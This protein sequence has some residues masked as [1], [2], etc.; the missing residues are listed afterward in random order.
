VV[1]KNDQGEVIE[2]ICSYDPESKGGDTPDGRRVKGTLQWVS[3]AHAVEAEV[4]LFDR[5]FG[6]ENPAK[7]PE[8]EDFTAN[9]NADSLTIL[10]GCKLEPSLS[11]AKPGQRFQY[12]RHGYFCVD[13]D[14]SGEKLVFN[15]TVPL[16]DSW[17]KQ[18]AGNKKKQ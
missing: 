5:L 7:A 13:P 14:S 8:G 12:M 3:A 4:R 18:Q 6:V 2:V 17:G 16:R 15:R 9:L 1:K 11:V 10:S